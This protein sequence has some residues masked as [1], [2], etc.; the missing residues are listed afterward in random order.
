[1][2]S[3]VYRPI[4]KISFQIHI[5]FKINKVQVL[6]SIPE[7]HFY[8]AVIDVYNWSFMT[9]SST[10]LGTLLGCG[11]CKFPTAGGVQ[12][13]RHNQMMRRAAVGTQPWRHCSPRWL[14]VPLLVLH[15]GFPFWDYHSYWGKGKRKLGLETV[16]KVKSLVAVCLFQL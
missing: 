16:Q 12:V 15:V 9:V 8:Y 3:S 2:N 11:W 14:W 1:M 10:R 5:I 7:N 13:Q 4:Y 6:P